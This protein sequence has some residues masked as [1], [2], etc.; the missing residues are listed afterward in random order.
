VRVSPGAR[1][2][3]VQGFYGDRLKVLVSAPPEDN[4]ANEE[5]RSFLAAALGLPRDYV[6]V[7]AGHKSKDKTLLLR[8]LEERDLQARL[9]QAIGPHHRG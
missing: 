2:T 9:E 1:Q 7:H 8:G 6:S 3:R 5:L 4:R